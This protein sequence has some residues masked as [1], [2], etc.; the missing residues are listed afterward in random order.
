MNFKIFYLI[1][2]FLFGAS[3]AKAGFLFDEPGLKASCHKIHSHA[4][5]VL[6]AGE[7]AK[8]LE[9]F[10][11]EKI[12]AKMT[13]S[14]NPIAS[15]V[16][17]GMASGIAAG[18][19]APAPGIGH[20]VGSGMFL[21]SALLNMGSAEA[22]INNHVLAW[23]PVNLAATEEEARD[24]FKNMIDEATKKVFISFVMAE[25]PSDTKYSRKFKLVGDDCLEGDCTLHMFQV[26][27]M[28][29]LGQAPEWLGGYKAWVFD[30][31]SGPGISWLT[32]WGR[33]VNHKYVP[34]L[35]KNLP[36]W[37]FVSIHPEANNRNIGQRMLL[38]FNEGKA[39]APVFPE[40]EITGI[41]TFDGLKK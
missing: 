7:M 5:C 23:M 3:V 22:M 4:W 38:V 15:T 2:V 30:R 9:D 21:A 40:I 1:A 28:P 20:A 6:S 26:L 16:S 12:E 19:V 36:K 13:T 18:V 25:V 14:G 37:V 41:P 8:G 17:L 10:P 39:Y 24:L 34:N 11:R 32:T 29:K 33:L 35:S 27:A 31:S